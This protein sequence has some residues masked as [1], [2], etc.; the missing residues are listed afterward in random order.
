[1][2]AGPAARIDIAPGTATLA[3]GQRVRLE[4]TAFSK[5]GDRRYAP[6]TWTSSA[7][8]IATVRSDG[9]LTAV[10]AGEAIITAKETTG[11]DVTGTV[12]VR[13]VATPVA[14]VDITPAMKEAKQGDVI[15]F[16]TVARDAQ[17]KEI[18]GLTPQWTMSPGQGSI[19][20]TA[21][22]S[23]TRPARTR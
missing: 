22:L 20:A 19:D 15:R 3:A 11:T 2:V 8:R 17:G 9:Q 7:P 4:A 10:G 13:V 5:A 18:P 14:A 1:M 12:R 21:P 6:F 23:V 16:Q